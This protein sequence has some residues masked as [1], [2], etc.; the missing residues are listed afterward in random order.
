[1]L[2]ISSLEALTSQQTNWQSPV[3]S[4]S[5]D[6]N[7]N[8][9]C[10]VPDYKLVGCQY[11]MWSYFWRSDISFF[12]HFAISQQDVKKLV[13]RILCVLTP[14]FGILPSPVFDYTHQVTKPGRPVQHR[15]PSVFANNQFLD[16]LCCLWWSPTALGQIARI[17]WHKVILQIKHLIKHLS[18][19]TKRVRL[20]IK[21][22]QNNILHYWQKHRPQHHH[23]KSKVWN[24]SLQLF[25]FSGTLSFACDIFRFSS[26]LISS[27]ICASVEDVSAKSHQ[28]FLPVARMC[29]FFR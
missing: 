26:Y 22:T 15:L 17:K 5:G 29:H 2:D 27:G 10:T 9:P 19:Y 14:R 16:F 12:N 6:V 20:F 21:F 24:S 28:R 8:V 11:V 13:K 3:L 7:I 25:A 1:M 23:E 4:S 18:A